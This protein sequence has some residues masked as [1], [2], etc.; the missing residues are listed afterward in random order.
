[1]FAGVLE[2]KTMGKVIKIFE[3]KEEEFEVVQPYMPVKAKTTEWETPDYLYKEYDDKYHFDLDAAATP[4]NAKCKKFFTKEDNGLQKSW[5]GY[6]VW[7]N[8]PY[9]AKNLRDF[10]T[11]VIDQVEK[12]GI[13]V[14]MLVPVK[15]DQ[16]WWHWLWD[17][18]T[19]AKWP[20]EYDWILGRLKFVGAS[21]GATFPSVVIVVRGR[22][23]R[24]RNDKAP[25]EIK[26]L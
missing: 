23:E 4:A 22:S 26:V 5:K 21:S 1:V 17:K 11:K 25:K 10:T 19:K 13:I 15:T 12:Y 3:P 7:L 2:V 20:M 9:D 18:Y 16:P 6:T 14:V 24:S 8:P